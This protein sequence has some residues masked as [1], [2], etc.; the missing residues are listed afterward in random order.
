[1]GAD[2]CKQHFLDQGEVT[3]SMMQEYEPVSFCIEEEDLEVQK[4]ELFNI[5]ALHVKDMDTGIDHP[6]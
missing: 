6:G 4:K 1:M 3:Q 2:C 5:A